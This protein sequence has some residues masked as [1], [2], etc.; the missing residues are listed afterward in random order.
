MYKIFLN[1][2]LILFVALFAGCFSKK[3]FA[4]LNID[5]VHELSIVNTR[6]AQINSCKNSKVIIV[7]TYLNPIKISLLKNDKENF[8]V[9]I[10]IDKQNQA[11]NLNP[12]YKILLNNDNEIDM[13]K[14]IDKDSIYMKMIPLVN[15]WADYYLIQF[16][17][18]DTK[19]LALVFQT[20]NGSKALLAF[21]KEF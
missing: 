4:D 6:K 7:A 16:P 21:E 1:V 15:K 3:K 8:I 10:Y 20:N 19:K 17:K 11:K 12:F 13:I 9:G 5:K 2:V 14:K 18:K